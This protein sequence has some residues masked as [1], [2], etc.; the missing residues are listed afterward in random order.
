[1]KVYL[2][3][4]VEKIGM[5][6]EV[7]KVSDGFAANFLIPNKMGLEITPANEKSFANKKKVIE[8]RKEVIST[9]TSMLAERIK[10]I[11]LTLK[12]K[13]HDGDK[14][15]GAIAASEI[16]ELLGAEGVSV[17]KNQI[18]FDK[19]IKAKG[20]YEVTIKLSSKLQPKITVV[21]APE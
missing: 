2:L 20:S 12:R 17:T 21:I 7:V 10:S 14:L 3:K 8:Q 19:P 15:Y 13:L 1:M 6:G 18:E 16:A 9:K 5:A 11:K 4:D